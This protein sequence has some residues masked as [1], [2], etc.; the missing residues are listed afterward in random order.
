MSPDDGVLN[1]PCTGTYGGPVFP[2]TAIGGFLQNGTTDLGENPAYS[3]ATALVVTFVVNNH[4]NKTLNLPA[5]EWEKKSVLLAI[6][7]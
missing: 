6:V 4:N 7:C 1:L 3:N 5:M 2:Y